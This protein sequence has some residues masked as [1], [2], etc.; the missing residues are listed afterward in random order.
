MLEL[1]VVA[2]G[3]I[4]SKGIRCSLTLVLPSLFAGR[5]YS[6]RQIK[7]HKSRFM[8]QNANFLEGISQA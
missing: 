7:P 4:F 3:S 6:F 2:V 5:Y 8:K 1:D